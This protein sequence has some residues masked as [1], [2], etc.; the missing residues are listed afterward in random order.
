M[1]QQF[2]EHYKYNGNKYMDGSQM[3]PWKKMINDMH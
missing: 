3:N 2:N 1:V